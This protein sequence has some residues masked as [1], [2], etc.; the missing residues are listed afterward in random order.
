MQIKIH[1]LCKS[2]GSDADRLPNAENVQKKTMA[3]LETAPKTRRT[4]RWSIAAAV[5]AAVLVLAGSAWAISRAISVRQVE[6]PTYTYDGETYVYDDA[7]TVVKVDV[8]EE[9]TVVAFHAN[10]LPETAYQSLTASVEDYR[11]DFEQ[12]GETRPESAMDPETLQ[13]ALLYLDGSYLDAEGQEQILTVTVYSTGDLK[14]RDYVVLGMV[15]LCE[16]R[17]LCGMEATYLQFDQ[18]GSTVRTILL[19]DAARGCVIQL[20]SSDSF[21]LLEQ[22]AAGLELIDTDIVSKDMNPG[23][24]WSCI[25]VAHG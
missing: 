13:D 19:Y 25:T 20:G 18:G 21:E 12:R 8:P 9:G 5:A 22:V 3:R 2:V 24:D 11:N 16:E 10:W 1:D 6:S 4:P 7:N 14:N 23:W 17:E 15:E